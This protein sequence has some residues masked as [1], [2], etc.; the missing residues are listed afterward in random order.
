MA[1]FGT[2]IYFEKVLLSFIFVFDFWPQMD[3]IVF[4]QLCACV[5]PLRF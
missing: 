2:E 5:I 3:D 4:P 1:W